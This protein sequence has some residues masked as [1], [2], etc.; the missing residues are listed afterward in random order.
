MLFHF[1]FNAILH[2]NFNRLISIYSWYLMKPNNFDLQLLCCLQYR[3]SYV[4]TM[5]KKQVIITRNI[6][7]ILEYKFSNARFKW[8]KLK[9]KYNVLYTQWIM[10][11]FFIRWTCQMRKHPLNH[12]KKMWNEPKNNKCEMNQW[13]KNKRNRHTRNKKHIKRVFYFPNLKLKK[14]MPEF[15]RTEFDKT[16]AIALNTVNFN[17][18]VSLCDTRKI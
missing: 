13:E 2:R 12:E 16:N 18:Y 5:T 9:M 17:P 15:N 4:L 3:Y 10:I 11:Y 7:G 8:R 6:F 1:I 14:K